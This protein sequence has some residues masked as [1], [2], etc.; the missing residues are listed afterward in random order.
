MEA[1]AEILYQLRAR[2]I[3]GIVIVD[4]IDMSKSKDKNT[5]L[6]A[7]ASMAADDPKK[8]TIIGMTKLGLVEITRKKTANN[9]L[10]TNVSK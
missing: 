9:P 2:N 4:F 5:L 7:L 8:T 6:Q 3:S 10:R 1:G